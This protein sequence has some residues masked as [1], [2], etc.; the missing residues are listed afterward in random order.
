MLR[1]MVVAGLVIG[2]SLPTWSQSLEEA[3]KA[4]AK[5]FPGMEP[6]AMAKGLAS[7]LVVL[8][9]EQTLTFEYEGMKV[10]FRMAGGAVLVE[11]QTV[12]EPRQASR[13]PLHL[14]RPLSPPRTSPGKRPPRRST[15][16]PTTR[17]TRTGTSS[18]PTAGRWY[19]SP[20]VT[21]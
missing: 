7:M 20:R 19:G 17:L 21:S 1:Q 13:T 9:D 6:A 15:G 2:F 12:G 11:R 3:S 8:P 10:V 4:V 5:G 18:A 14:P 16:D